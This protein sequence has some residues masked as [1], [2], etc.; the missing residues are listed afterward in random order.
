MNENGHLPWQLEAPNIENPTGDCIWGGNV[1]IDGRAGVHN[2]N[3]G[4]Y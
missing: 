4:L 1:Y 3:S 2:G